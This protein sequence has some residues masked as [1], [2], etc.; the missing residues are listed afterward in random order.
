MGHAKAVAGNKDIVVMGG[1]NIA[2]QCIKA[3]L[4]DEI[5]IHLAPVL[6]GKGIRLFD[7]IGSMPVELQSTMVSESPGVTHLRFRIV[8]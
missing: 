2:S 6:L 7:D 3:G 4:L 5:R 8:K 1:G